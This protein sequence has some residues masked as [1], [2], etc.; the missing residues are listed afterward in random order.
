[1]P[2]FRIYFLPEVSGNEPIDVDLGLTSDA[3]GV[4]EGPEVE[5]RRGDVDD[6]HGFGVFEVVSLD[7]V[8][9][10]SVRVGD[11]VWRNWDRFEYALFSAEELEV[12]MRSYR[13]IWK[14]GPGW[15]ELRQK[16]WGD[17]DLRR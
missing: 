4:I 7:N 15:L 9:D 5:K 14:P 8:P 10:C 3:I 13:P 6:P 17:V 1:M 16:K 12:Q 11:V 2:L